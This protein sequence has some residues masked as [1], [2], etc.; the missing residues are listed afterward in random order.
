MPDRNLACKTC[1]TKVFKSP[2]EVDNHHQESH[3][4]V[5]SKPGENHIEAEDQTSDQEQPES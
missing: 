2:G 5:E 3:P 1:G 4:G